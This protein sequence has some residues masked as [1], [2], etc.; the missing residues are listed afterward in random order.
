MKTRFRLNRRTIGLLSLC[1]L[2]SLSAIQAQTETTEK[3]LQSFV[4]SYKKDHM[5]HTVTFGIKVGEDWWHVRSQ[6]KQE[7]YAVG[8]KKQYTFHNFGPHTV[9]LHKG[10][11]NKPTWY[12]HFA[13]KEVLNNIYSKKWTASTAS[14]KSFGS[15]VVGLNIRDM[16]GYK[17][18]IQEDALAYEVMEHFWKKD[19]VEITYFTRDAS[20]PTHGVDHVGLYTMKDKRIGWFSIGPEQAANTERGLDKGQ[21]PN[22]FI[23]TKGKGRAELGEG[24][25]ELEPGMSIF[26]GPYVKHVI[27]NPYDEPLEGI[28][29]LFG[30]NSDYVFGKSYMDLLEDQHKFYGDYDKSLER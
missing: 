18:G 19:A 25:V 17:S 21:V 13:N 12:F 1:M 30:D 22:L 11:P 29:V 10:K 8:K 9:S 4:D 28:L 16:K 24:V 20:L 23:I 27:Y 26:I 14:A 2:C 15:D 7:G 3:M 6:R 5:A